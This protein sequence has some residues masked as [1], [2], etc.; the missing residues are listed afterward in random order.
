MVLIPFIISFTYEPGYPPSVM[1][2]PSTNIVLI[3]LLH[4]PSIDGI[5]EIFIESAACW[6][7][8]K[9]NKSLYHSPN[10]V[11]LIYTSVASG[12]MVTVLLLSPPITCLNAVIGNALLVLIVK[13]PIGL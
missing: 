9:L 1:L 4:I 2:E 6:F 8:L 3:K 11:N 10:N 5:I 12:I 13:S 7:F